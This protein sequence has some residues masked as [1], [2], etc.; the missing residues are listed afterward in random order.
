VTLGLAVAVMLGWILVSTALGVWRTAT[1][2]A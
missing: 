2:D 1:Q